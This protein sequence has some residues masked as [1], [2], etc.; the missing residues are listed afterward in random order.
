MPHPLDD[1]T[2]GD[3]IS[4]N[5]AAVA[6]K[7]TDK[8]D[9]G[10][11]VNPELDVGNLKDLVKNGPPDD[12]APT[13]K[14]EAKPQPQHIPKARFDE[15]N[16]KKNELAEQLAEANRQIEAM[17]APRQDEPTG[18]VA[19][20]QAFDVNAMEKQYIEALMEGK[21]DQA[22]TI[23]MGINSYLVNQ[24][25]Y[26]ANAEAENRQ[27]ATTLQSASNQAVVDYPYLD[28]PEGDVA[29]ELI[30][31]SRDA[32]I[33]QGI[34]PAEALRSSVA[35]IAPKFAPETDEKPLRFDEGNAP[36][37]TRTAAALARGA[38]DSN[39]QPPSTQVGTGNRASAGRVNVAEMTEEQFE[40]MSLADKKRA[41][42]DV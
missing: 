4:V 10:D 21:A 6:D 15:V 36:K 42:G 13:A 39:L 25:T 28:T 5:G 16:T 14:E 8:E 2:T 23:R 29:L 30:I 3:V 22:A 40:N 33:A 1:D 12:P 7:P 32:K 18:R 24:A 34:S 35:L 37:D 17:R 31:A 38:A 9:R 19:Q 27:Q 26:A 41:R 11:V 20:E